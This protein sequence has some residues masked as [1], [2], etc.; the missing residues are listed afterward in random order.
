MCRCFCFVLGLVAEYMDRLRDCPAALTCAS[1]SACRY[2]ICISVGMSM[3]QRSDMITCSRTGS[4]TATRTP[5][6]DSYDHSHGTHGQLQPHTWHTW[7]ATHRYTHGTHGQ[8]QPHTD[9]HMA[10]MVSYSHTHAATGRQAGWMVGSGAGHGS[11]QTEYYTYY[12]QQSGVRRILRRDTQRQPGRH[13]D[14][15]AA[16]CHQQ[17][18]HT[19]ILSQAF[20]LAHTMLS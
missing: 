16:G 13:G 20:A 1:S 19:T 4:A 3:E 10:H 12:Y 8:L 6:M 15:H 7:S 14:Q 18:V 17:G 5:S 9:T 11:T 2:L